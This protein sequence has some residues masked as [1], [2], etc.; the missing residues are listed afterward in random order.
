MVL[1]KPG[2]H[3]HT[4]TVVVC[5]P[6]AVPLSHTI[7]ERCQ[8]PMFLFKTHIFENFIHCILII[9]TPSSTFPNLI[10]IQWYVIKNYPVQLVIA[11]YSSV[12][13]GYLL[14][15]VLLTWGHTIKNVKLPLLTSI[16][17]NNSSFSS[18]TLCLPHLS[19]RRTNF[20]YLKKSRLLTLVSNIAELTRR[21]TRLR[22]LMFPNKENFRFALLVQ[23]KKMHP[24]SSEF[25]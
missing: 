21:S 19:M 3:M 8:K 15:N 12:V 22:F 2:T 24:S 1:G 23:K 14:E 16:N 18:E 17:S 7:I 20:D 9:F 25:V 10:P 11:I 6:R 4:C 13:C 5:P